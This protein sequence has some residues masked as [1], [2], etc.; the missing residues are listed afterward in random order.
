MKRQKDRINLL[1]CVIACKKR[2]RRIAGMS[3]VKCV[4]AKVTSQFFNDEQNEK[5]EEEEQKKRKAREPSCRHDTEGEKLHINFVSHQQQ[6]YEMRE[7]EKFFS[8]F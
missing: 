4:S 5:T 2:R 8:P 7:K 3:S 1:F 6:N